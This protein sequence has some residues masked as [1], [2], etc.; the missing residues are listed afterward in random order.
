M[1]KQENIHCGALTV[2]KY[3]IE[4]LVKKFN[5]YQSSGPYSQANS[6]EPKMTLVF[7]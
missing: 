7:S 5:Y 3:L 6:D 1:S 2:G 4:L